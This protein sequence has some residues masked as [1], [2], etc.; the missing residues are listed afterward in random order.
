MGGLIIFV[1]D[2]MVSF[3]IFSRQ[4]QNMADVHFEKYDSE[5]KGSEQVMCWETAKYLLDKYEYINREEDM[6]IEGLRQS[7]RSYD[8]EFTVK[9]YKLYRVK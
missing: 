6:G 5:I 3:S 9:T 8:P 7:K 2:R 4:N 1:K